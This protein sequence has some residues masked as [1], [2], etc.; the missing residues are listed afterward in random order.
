MRLQC[1]KKGTK[2]P[3]LFEPSEEVHKLLQEYD[4]ENDLLHKRAIELIWIS[5]SDSDQ[6]SISIF[7]LERAKALME[8]IWDQKDFKALEV[9]NLH[10]P[11]QW[12]NS[13]SGLL[14]R[15]PGKR[16]E[17]AALLHYLPLQVI[18][19]LGGGKY[20]A[21]I[22]RILQEWQTPEDE[23]KAILSAAD[24][25]IAAKCN[26]IDPAD[27]AVLLKE[28]EVLI[29]RLKKLKVPLSFELILLEELKEIKENRIER[30]LELERV[31]PGKNTVLQN[32][33]IANSTKTLDLES[34]DPL[35]KA[36]S[37]QLTALAFSGAR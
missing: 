24:L 29:Q 36:K 33:S 23:L 2:V 26:R 9:S 3:D 4:A 7:F 20:K 10:P 8:W 5:K 17:L 37:M 27:A 18:L 22:Q 31:Y 30:Q 16:T 34:S 32:I 19:A 1:S 35:L 15:Q 14:Y 21:K 6:M 28:D 11:E 13:I 25:K 12:R